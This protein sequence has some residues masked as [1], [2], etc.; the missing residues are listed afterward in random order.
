MTDASAPAPPSSP[1]ASSAPPNLPSMINDDNKL[2]SSG[3]TLTEEYVN[4]NCAKFRRMMKKQPPKVIRDIEAY[5]RIMTP[6]MNDGS[7]YRV[8]YMG[9]HLV[10]WV[11]KTQPD[12]RV[13]PE[14]W[15]D[16]EDLDT[17]NPVHFQPVA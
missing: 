17:L 10:N 11:R 7:D 16:E 4:A 5:N 6:I 15:E 13:I 1:A 9:Y 14:C 2:I 8:A 12:E 3:I